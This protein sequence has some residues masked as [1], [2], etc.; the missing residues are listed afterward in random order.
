MNEV[1]QVLAAPL[2]EERQAAQRVDDFL[3]DVSTEAARAMKKHSPM[4]SLHEAYAVILE[5][6]DEFKA[7]VWMKQGERDPQQVYTELVQLAAMVAR[8]V[9]DC[10]P[11]EF[12]K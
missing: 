6:M 3:I 12:K 2:S 11:D 9:A 4:H 10:G 7:H 1:T 8:C 5:E